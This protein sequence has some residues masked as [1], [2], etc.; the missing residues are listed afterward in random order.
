MRLY[1]VRHG[2]TVENSSGIIQGQ[3]PGT[4]SDRGRKQIAALA[5]RLQAERITHIYSSDLDRAKLTAEAIAVKHGLTVAFDSRLR[6]KAFGIFEGR[7]GSVY[8]EAFQQSG[9]EAAEYRPEGGESFLDLQLRTDSFLEEISPVRRG[10]SVLICTHGG[11]IRALLAR[12]LSL[13]IGDAV[14]YPTDNAAL[15]IFEVDDQGRVQLLAEN[16]VQH[17][18]DGRIAN[19][20]DRLTT[21]WRKLRRGI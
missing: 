20:E 18:E 10:D 7:E 12:L 15:W 16:E 5:S 11:V 8:F 9:Q 13:S 17:L 21:F 2:E 14:F 3:G 4:L 1:I 19:R 6:E